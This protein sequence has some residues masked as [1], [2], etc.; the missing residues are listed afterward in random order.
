MTAE[1]ERLYDAR[2]AKALSHPLRARILEQLE[3]QTASP[4]D[5]AEQLAAPLGNVSYH[6][7][8]LAEAGLIELVRTTRRRGA[9]EHH[10]R[11]AASE[12]ITR[13][14]GRDLTAPRP[15]ASAM[16]QAPVSAPGPDPQAPSPARRTAGDARGNED[17]VRESV[18]EVRRHVRLCGGSAAGQAHVTRAALVLDDE[19]W[20]ELRKAIEQ[21]HDLALRLQVESAPRLR[22][23][24]HE[25]EHDA[26]LVLM[27]F[28]AADPQ[29]LRVL[30]GGIGERRS[31]SDAGD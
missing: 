24:G 28:E 5:L 21:L 11:A 1:P 26:N 22:Q 30:R 4:S 29:A 23:A 20:S 31:S 14:D 18:A 10:Y 9:T 6:V 12:P 25:R 16:G 13:S 2:L 8:I 27:L 17:P 3:R 7:R 19:A 15:A